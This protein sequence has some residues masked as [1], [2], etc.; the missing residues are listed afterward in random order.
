MMTVTVARGR[1]F[2]VPQF[3]DR[4][5]DRVIDHR[6]HESMTGSVTEYLQTA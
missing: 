1:W 4:R 2:A 5:V 6:P 3:V